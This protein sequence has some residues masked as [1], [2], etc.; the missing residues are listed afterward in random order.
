MLVVILDLLKYHRYV[1]GE[2][3]L[4]L[5]PKLGDGKKIVLK[6]EVRGFSS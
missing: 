6:N 4:S 5:F 1:Y 2:S 3:L